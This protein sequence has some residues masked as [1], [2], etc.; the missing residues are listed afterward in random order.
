MKLWN[1]ID[2]VRH[3]TYEDLQKNKPNHILA[4][5][6]AKQ[7]RAH[8]GPE[9][10]Q[11]QRQVHVP[12]AG[13][14]FFW[15]HDE[16]QKCQLLDS[17]SLCH[18]WISRRSFN[19]AHWPIHFSHIIFGTESWDP[20]RARWHQRCQAEDICPW[21]IVG[22]VWKSLISSNFPWKIQHHPLHH[23]KPSLIQRLCDKESQPTSNKTPVVQPSPP[24]VAS[25]TQPLIPDSVLMLPLVPRPLK[26]WRPPEQ[27]NRKEQGEIECTTH[28]ST[29]HILIAKLLLNAENRKT[30][31]SWQQ[32][33]LTHQHRPATTKWEHLHGPYVDFFIHHRDHLQTHL[34]AASE[35]LLHALT[36]IVA[37]QPGR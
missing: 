36:N 19:T 21:L 25:F 8:S 18:L 2:N 6:C 27:E 28:P 20:N 7:R 35:T 32:R 24:L 17:Y 16:Q 5:C 1:Q 12:H 15:M 3:V 29:L 22:K 9:P 11:E 31:S 37:V 14:V 10:P 23:W 13:R 4:T 26:H 33:Q 34:P 30:C